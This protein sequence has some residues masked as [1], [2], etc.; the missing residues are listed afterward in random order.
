ML[1]DNIREQLPNTKIFLLEPFIFEY[2]LTKSTPEQPDRWQSI[3]SEVSQKASIAKKIAAKYGL[4]FVELQDKFDG[5][6]ERLGVENV[7]LDGLH[8]ISAGHYLIAKEWI[9]CFEENY[10]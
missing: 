10:R 6:V 5:L 2:T 1:L 4:P 3:K 9:K 7:T 8:P